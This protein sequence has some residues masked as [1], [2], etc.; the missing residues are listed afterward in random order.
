M[1]KAFDTVDLRKLLKVIKS[2]TIKDNR[3]AKKLIT[4]TTM[5]VKI[6]NALSEPFET[7]LGAQQGDAF[8]PVAFIIY[9]EAALRE[10]RRT[11]S[12]LPEDKGPPE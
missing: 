12:H 6:E 9:L 11:C 8:S 5:Q 1:S 2:I 10:V 7:T 4:S 3:I